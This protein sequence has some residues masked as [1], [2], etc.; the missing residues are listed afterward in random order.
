MIINT[1]EMKRF[2]YKAIIGLFLITVPLSSCDGDL[3]VDPQHIQNEE[4]FLNN[5]DNAVQ[6][7]NGVYNKMLNYNMYSFSWIGMTSITS[8]D[9]IH[10]HSYP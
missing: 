8:D 9:A 10:R 2:P 4:D 7:V 1:L 6:L 3:D 5:P